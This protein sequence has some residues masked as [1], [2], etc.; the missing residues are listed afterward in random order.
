MIRFLQLLPSLEARTRL[1]SFG[2][3]TCNT[4]LH[5]PSAPPPHAVYWHNH[6]HSPD[7]STITV[8]NAPTSPPRPSAAA[9]RALAVARSPPALQRRQ[10][11]APMRHRPQPDRCGCVSSQH[12]C[13]AVMRLPALLRRIVPTENTTRRVAAVYKIID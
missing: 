11:C 1:T 2:N 7:T 6:Y 8:S 13:P 10:N 5:S 9:P 3:F 12:R 4:P